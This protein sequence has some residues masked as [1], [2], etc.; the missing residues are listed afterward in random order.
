MAAPA[1]SLLVLYASLAFGTEAPVRVGRTGSAGFNG[2]SGRPGPPEWL[3]GVHFAAA[4][5]LLLA[6][7]RGTVRRGSPGP[8]P[9]PGRKSTR[10]PRPRAGLQGPSPAPVPRRLKPT[11]L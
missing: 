5:R 1:L 7:H 2:V 3:G 9:V 6:A 8:P 11:P 10:T 4:V